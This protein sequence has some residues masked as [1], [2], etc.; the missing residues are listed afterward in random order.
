MPIDWQALYAGLEASI[1]RYDCGK[2]CAPLSE[3]GDPYCCTTQ[4]TIPVVFYDEWQYLERKTELW[5]RYAPQDKT[6]QNL[7]ADAGAGMVAVECK[8]W[9]ACEREYRSLACRTF[10]FYPY[11]NKAGEFLGLSYYWAYEER[12]WVISHLELVTPEYL[13]QFVAVYTQ[14]FA[15][16]PDEHAAYR[17]YSATARRVFSRW[18]RQIPLLHRNG[19]SYAVHPTTAALTATAPEDFGRHGPYLLEFETF[20]K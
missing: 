3:T 2:Q 12:C 16:M 11:V 17:Q 10:P 5:Q 4:H 7:V 18:K 13:Q 20:E 19:N 9:D 8:G 6:R 1:T 15:E 14:L